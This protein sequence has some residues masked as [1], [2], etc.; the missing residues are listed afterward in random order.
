[1]LK[2]ELIK[3]GPNHIYYNLN[4][5]NSSTGFVPLQFKDYRGEGIIDLSKGEYNLTVAR[6]LIPGTGIPLFSWPTDPNSYKITFGKPSVLMASVP[7]VYVPNNATG[8]RNV[9]SIQQ[10]VD[11]INTALHTGYVAFNAAYGGLVSTA[12]Y[13]V[14]DTTTQLFSLIAEANYAINN[15]NIYFNSNL[16]LFFDN[17][18]AYFNGTNLANGTDYQILIKN[19][20]NNYLSAIPLP[21]LGPQLTPIGYKMSQEYSNTYL[22]MS[23]RSLVITS[24]LLP[25]RSEF[26][27][28]N[29]SSATSG[30][31][32][33][34][35][36]LSVLT[37]FEPGFESVRD[38]R[39]YMHYQPSLYRWIDLMGDTTIK[40]A[41]INVY[42]VDN[43]QVLHPLFL[44]PGEYFSIKI[45]FSRKDKNNYS[46]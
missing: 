32:W 43:K 42:W 40:Q 18:E 6:F 31:Q 35:S 16:Y 19:N 15:V 37:D 14:F 3:E 46:N 4:F 44:P 38:V 20:G 33:S 39:S 45:L 8:S 13:M 7:L 30:T 9:Y 24:S 21:P 25:L 41:D 26:Y 28:L 11:I 10:F 1:M 2:S 5:A 23:F 27:P 12:P 34:Q 29:S 17:I 36:Q 22:L